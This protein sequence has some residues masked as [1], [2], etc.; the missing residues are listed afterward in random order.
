MSHHR[1][2]IVAMDNICCNRL[3]YAGIIYAYTIAASS[4][5]R[6]TD[7]TSLIAQQHQLPIR[8]P[9]AANH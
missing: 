1:M 8:S 4:L 9:N 6:G 3:V 7:A 5:A 2:T